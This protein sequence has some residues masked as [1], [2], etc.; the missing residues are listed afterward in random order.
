MENSGESSGDDPG[1]IQNDEYEV[2]NG[3]RAT[4]I[5]SHGNSE[6]GA[7]LPKM[8]DDETKR[9]ILWRRWHLIWALKPSYPPTAS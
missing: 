3:V 6:K 1:G 2:V 4:E 8:E 9:E 5:K 7:V